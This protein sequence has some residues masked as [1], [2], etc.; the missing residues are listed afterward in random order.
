MRNS[1][2]IDLG[3]TGYDELFMTEEERKTQNLTHV[4]EIP[5]DQID[6]FPAHPFQVRMD[7]DMLQLIESIRERGVISPV[8]LRKKDDNRYELISGHRRR[9][10][11]EILGI[12]T[13][14]A[15]IRDMTT[16]EAIIMMVESNLQ[17]TV[18]LPSEK[19]FSYKMRLDAM[20]RQQG[21]RSD[22]TSAPVEQMSASVSD[23]EENQQGSDAEIT[24]APME[25]KSSRELLADVSPDSHAQIQRYIRLTNLTPDLL[26]MVDEGKIALRPAVEL[27]YLK[28]E[29]QDMLVEEIKHSGSAPSNVQAVRLRALSNDSALGPN[30]IGSVINEAKPEP[31]KISLRYSE[32]RQYIPASIPRKQTKDYIMKALEYYHKHQEGQE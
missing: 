19:A 25:Q 3:M 27:S 11:C 24:S 5:I 7:E 8:L 32:A 6:D 4:V 1:N 13:I 14:K 16:D 21:F 30:V 26:K 10:A 12:P 31:D 23:K 22:L 20:K 2:K 28:P 17:R 9:R 15:V 18:I 29:E